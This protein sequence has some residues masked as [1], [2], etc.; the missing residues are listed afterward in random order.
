MREVTAEI[1]KWLHQRV[2]CRLI[3]RIS[4]KGRKHR[5]KELTQFYQKQSDAKKSQVQAKV[6]QEKIDTHD[7][8]VYVKKKIKNNH[9][10]SSDDDSDADSTISSATV[11]DA[12]TRKPF[13]A[14]QGAQT[15]DFT[16]Y[17]VNNACKQTPIPPADISNTDSNLTY[18]IQSKSYPNS[19]Q[20]TMFAQT[21]AFIMTMR[22][23]RKS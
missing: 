9:L 6:K 14:D 2:Q 17:R 12:K 10:S 15:S 11:L 20:R 23:K 4:T 19:S 18:R 21:Q 13:K 8:V 1:T 16:Q 5:Q 22:P 7:P 3:I